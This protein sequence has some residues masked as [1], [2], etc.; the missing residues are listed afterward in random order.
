MGSRT[1]SDVA[2]SPQ[3]ATK[4]AELSSDLVLVV[5]NTLP[6]CRWLL[7]RVTKVFPGEDARVRTAEVKTK[8]SRLIRPVTKLCLLE[9]AT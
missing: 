2:A 1:C 5:D 6:R 7:G 3:M 8:T 4:Q 9:E